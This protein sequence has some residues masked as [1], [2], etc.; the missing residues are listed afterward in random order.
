VIDAATI[1]KF[2]LVLV[3]PGMLVSTTPV[4]GGIHVPV[5][6]RIALGIMLSLTIA[7][8]VPPPQSV[9]T[10]GLVAVIGGEALIGIALGLGVRI[11]VG[12]AELAGHLAGFQIGFSH[13]SIVDPQSGVRNNVVAAL[14]ANL[15]MV[16]FLGIN[17]HHAVIRALAGSYEALPIGAAGVSGPLAPLVA[18]MLGLVFVTG[19]RLAA[20]VVTALLLVE[21]VMGLVAR[22]APSLNLF[23]VGTPLRLLAGMLALAAGIQVV[24]GVIAGATTPAL[25][26]AVRLVRAFH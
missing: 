14:Y 15:A 18:H 6:V 19:T 3:R 25:E 21:I 2:G 1:S 11:L 23:I 22:A 8:V 5:P 24:P 17:G 26:S 13:A 12:A 4:F 7:P 16:T 20:P 9:G 10:L